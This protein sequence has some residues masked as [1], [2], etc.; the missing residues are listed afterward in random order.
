VQKED[1]LA[2]DARMLVHTIIF[3][4]FNFYHLCGMNHLGVK[5]VTSSNYAQTNVIE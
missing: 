3:Y 2:C 5:H 1:A 4:Y